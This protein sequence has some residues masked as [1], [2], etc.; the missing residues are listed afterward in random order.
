MEDRIAAIDWTWIGDGLDHDGFASLGRLLN[1]EECASLAAAYR[2]D[3]DFRSTVT[4]ARHGFGAGEYKYFA[5]PLPPLVGD[6]RARLYARLTPVANGWRERFGDDKRYPTDHRSYRAICA[7][8]G[9]ARPTPLLLSYGPGD[10]NRLHRDIY[11]SETFPIQVAILLSEPGKEFE[12][13]EFVLTEQRPRMQSRAHVVPLAKGD[14]VAFAVNERPVD[15]AR[16]VYKAQMRHGVST[17]HRGRRMT[18]GVIFHD[19]A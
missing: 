7:A 10:Y 14:A 6:L 15:G 9:Q 17:V 13:G 16:G 1:D 8:A 19:A 18:L 11:G 2:A 4:M 5:D 3:R 12:G